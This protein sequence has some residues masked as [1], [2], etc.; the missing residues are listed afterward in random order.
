MP[1]PADDVDELLESHLRAEAVLGDD[2]VAELQSEP[3]CD[4]G[5]VA[6]GDVRERSAVDDGRHALERLHEVRLERG[7]EQRGHRARC[8]ELPRRNRLALDGGA[9]GDRAEPPP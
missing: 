6:V 3:V 4:D 2:V 8:S 9:D 1:L 5:I 7:R